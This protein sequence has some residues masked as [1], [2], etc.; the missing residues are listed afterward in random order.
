M[1]NAGEIE[2]VWSLVGKVAAV[3][4][5][6]V[7]LIQG[8]RYLY[9]LSPSAKLDQKISAIEKNLEKDYE[10]LKKHDDEIETL[11]KKLDH[12]SKQIDQL[13]Q[14]IHRLGKSQIALINHTIN[15]NGIDKL[16]EEVDDLTEF[17]I[18]R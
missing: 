7:A 13:N 17:F 18:D 14:G 2:A 3:I 5:V 4:G 11:N 16:R 9:S 6:T 12:T 1:V 10:H 8:I 15:G